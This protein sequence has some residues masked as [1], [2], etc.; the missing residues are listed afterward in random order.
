MGM[1]TAA[2][3]KEWAWKRPQELEGPSRKC[4]LGSRVWHANVRR[5]RGCGTHVRHA[6]AHLALVVARVAH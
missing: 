5:T 3:H 2:K 6:W 4:P 1:E